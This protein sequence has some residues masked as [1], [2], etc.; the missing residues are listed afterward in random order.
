MLKLLRSQEVESRLGIKH[1]K[2]AQLVVDGLLPRPIRLAPNDA[3]WPAHEIDQIIAARISGIDDQG[4]CELVEQLH[5][6]RAS[7]LARVR[8]A[9]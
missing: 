8:Q 9:A 7:L 1:S 6:E 4:I 3:K 5:A 2:R